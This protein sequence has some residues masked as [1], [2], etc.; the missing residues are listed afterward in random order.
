M[1]LQYREGSL[2]A[3]RRAGAVA[4]A[5]L[6]VAS[7]TQT[8]GPLETR[9]EAIRQQAEGVRLE[10][11]A[12]HGGAVLDAATDGRYAYIGMGPRLLVLDVSDR[13]EPR[14]MS[15]SEVVEGVVN[16]V[17]VT[18]G[19]ALAALNRR[20][21]CYDCMDGERVRVFEVRDPRSA[22]VG[23]AYD[24]PAGVRDMAASGGTAF[25]ACGAA[26]LRALD[27]TD[28]HHPVELAAVDGV[29][30]ARAVGL[31]AGYV[32]VASANGH[33]HAVD[34]AD[35]QQPQVVSSVD[36]GVR[37][38]TAL[39]VSGGYG[40]VVGSG[41]LSVV[42]V[43]DPRR[44]AE[45]GHVE[46]RKDLVEIAVFGSLALA[47]EPVIRSSGYSGC[48]FDVSE[49]TDP[50]LTDG[51]FGT[52][53][54]RLASGPGVVLVANDDGGLAVVEASG[55]SGLGWVAELGVA[56]SASA[57]D[58]AGSYAYVASFSGGLQV[59][60][61]GTPQALEP[62]ARLH[63]AQARSDWYWAPQY[64]VTIAGR[65]AYLAQGQNRLSSWSGLQI[66]DISD[67]RYPYEAGAL[68]LPMSEGR[69]EIPGNAWSVAISGT[70]A[71]LTDELYG[72][73]NIVDVSEPGAPYLVEHAE[74]EYERATTDVDIVGDT[75]Y[76]TL[77]GNGLAIV[78]IADP[79]EPALLRVVK[80]PGESLAVASDGMRAYVAS[81][82]GG[83]QVVDV[84]DPDEAELT[85]NNDALETW[86]VAEADGRVYLLGTPHEDQ[87]NHGMVYIWVLDTS[88]PGAPVEVA[89]LPIPGLAWVGG[90][91]RIVD[92]T[93]WVA[94]GDAGLLAYR[95]I[96]GGDVSPSPTPE[97][98]LGPPPS[99]TAAP[100]RR[101][102]TYLPWLGRS[103]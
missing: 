63:T 96:P 36:L 46:E 48:I 33:A 99:P 65:Y 51:G 15:A 74:I 100:L 77:W 2:R 83:L 54:G 86:G 13:S 3:C 5:A 42:D 24:C 85:S 84:A 26:G 68:R 94:A 93:V 41:G 81:E 75:A 21:R 52:S 19:V 103:W 67:P 50:V 101:Q 80:L 70:H 18:D 23:G 11:V 29:G 90:R 1:A 61:L 4:I 17:A 35:P 97:P 37:T 58:V 91:P 64:D 55:T 34:V 49:P 71:F 92:D 14:L 82:P 31:S 78:D 22:V 89:R 6:L 53:G 25:L 62:I 87:V 28:P 47:L 76:V 72:G 60:D 10:P 95:I 69:G 38:A 98:T 59:L 57:V 79:A 40:Y 73:L 27:V 32:L 44:L 88:G 43:G 7:A 16:R 102:V 9:A 30:N 45:V 12:Q 66:V 20:S 56:G 39:D 8:I